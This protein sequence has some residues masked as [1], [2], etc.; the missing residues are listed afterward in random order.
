MEKKWDGSTHTS[1]FQVPAHLH[2]GGQVGAEKMLKNAETGFFFLIFL[3][4]RIPKA[5]RHVVASLQKASSAWE[6]KAAGLQP[7]GSPEGLHGVFWDVMLQKD[8]IWCQRLLVPVRM[9]AFVAG[10]ELLCAGGTEGSPAAG[11]QSRLICLFR[12]FLR[13]RWK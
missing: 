9:D 4:E 7:R 8:A 2:L 3:T 1:A 12:G 5:A 10:L 11:S 6:A 13:T